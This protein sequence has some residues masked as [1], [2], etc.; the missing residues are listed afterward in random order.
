MFTLEAVSRLGFL[1]L[2]KERVVFFWRS[3]SRSKLGNVS[4]SRFLARSPA[5]INECRGANRALQI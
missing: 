2:A 3:C 1:G 5:I 4:V